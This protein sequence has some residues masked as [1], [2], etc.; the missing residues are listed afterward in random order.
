MKY[1]V[2]ILSIFIFSCKNTE[3]TTTQ[4]EVVFKSIQRNTQSGFHEAE[5]A[6]ISSQEKL[7]EIWKQAWSHF[8]DIP[9][10]P[11]IDFTQNQLLLIALGGKNNGGYGLEID[12]IDEG[13]NEMIVNYFETKAGGK[14]MTT[15][16]I[17]FPYELVEIK[18]SSKKVTFKSTEKVVDC[19]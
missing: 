12:K 17:V 8:S 7:D 2:I 13:N 4:Q 3:Q 5:T 11:K 9:P 19:N 6:V 16:A 15:Q 1:I 18:K 14:C 10:V